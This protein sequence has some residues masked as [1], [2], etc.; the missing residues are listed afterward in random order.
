MR[1]GGQGPRVQASLNSVL[2]PESSG[3]PSEVPPTLQGRATIGMHFQQS[4]WLSCG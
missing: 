4:L 1:G 3:G 2:Y